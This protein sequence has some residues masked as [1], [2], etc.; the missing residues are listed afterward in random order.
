MMMKSLLPAAV[1][2]GALAA[3]PVA[4]AATTDSTAVE[5]AFL[6]TQPNKSQR[7]LALNPG[8]AVNLISQGQHVRGYTSGLGT[9]QMTGPDSARATVIDFNNP[10]TTADGNGASHIVYDLTFSDE[11]DGQFQNVTGQF[12]GQAFARGQNPLADDAQPARNFGNRF[13]GMRIGVN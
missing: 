11:I 7:V 2:A 9:W 13:D 1:M 10:E 8:G 4:L 12:S 6:L 5:G 3:S